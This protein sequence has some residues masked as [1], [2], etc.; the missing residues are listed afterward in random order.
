MKTWKLS[1]SSELPNTAGEIIA[2]A[3]PQKK[4]VVYG[5]MGAGKT[6]LIKEICTLLGVQ[7]NTSSPTFAIVNEYQ[8]K[9]KIYHFDLFRIKD[10]SELEDIGFE[11]YLQGD[12]YV[13]VE[14]PALAEK[15]TWHY[16][17]A[18]I[19]IELT[20]NNERLITLER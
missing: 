12:D 8:G 1:S 17:F 19:L 7:E 13:F 9:V 2:F 14:W 16:N 20:E 15:I 4:F 6:T 5:E 11:E 3:Q 18:K 10:K